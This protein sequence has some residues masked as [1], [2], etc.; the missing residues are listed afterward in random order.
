MSATLA[1]QLLALPESTTG[2]G[3]SFN[4]SV[5]ESSASTTVGFNCTDWNCNPSN[6][7]SLTVA[8]NGTMEVRQTNTAC[9]WNGTYYD[10][11]VRGT[12]P[13]AQGGPQGTPLPPGLSTVSVQV[14]YLGSRSS[15]S[16][17]EEYHLFVSMYFRLSQN[18]TLYCSEGGRTESSNY[19]D[20][21]VR[22]DN[23]NGTDRPQ[24]SSPAY[25]GSAVGA[26]GW[27]NNV[28]SLSPGQ[29]GTLTANATT[30]CQQAEAAWGIS[31]IPCTLTGIEIGTEGYGISSLDTNWYSVTYSLQSSAVPSGSSFDHIVMIAMENQYYSTVLGTGTGASCCPF[32]TSLL[33][34]SATIPNFH[35]YGANDFSGDTISGCSA[36]CYTA[37]TSGG[38]YGVSDG[39][40]GG[41][42]SATNIFDRLTGAGLTWKGFCEDNCPRNADHFPLLQYADTYQSTC[43]AASS[44][45]C[46]LY[47]C[48]SCTAADVSDSQLIAELNSPSPA[49]YIWFTPTDEHNMHNV[50]PSSGDAYLKQILVG[51]GTVSSPSPG[52]ML[53]TTAFTS[54]HTLLYIWFDEYDPSP[55][56]LYEPGIVRSGFISTANNYDEYASL[57]TI[58]NNWSLLGLNLDTNA[59]LISDI[60]SPTTSMSAAFTY[61]PPVPTAG[62]AVTFVASAI[63]GTPVYTYSWDFGDG[64]S[65]TG[66]SSTHAYSSAGSYN[67]L[68]TVKD[69]GSPQQT[70]PSQQTVTVTSPPPPLSASFTF[71]PSSP[72]TEQQVTFTASSTGGTAPY[73]YSWSFGDGSIGTGSTSTHAYSSAGSFTVTLTVKDTGSPQQTVTSQKTVTVTSP[74]PTLT[75]SF[76][77]SPSSPQTGQQ[78]TFTAS[79]GGGTTP[80][81]FSWSFGDGSTGTGASV[82]HAYS[83]AGS[84]TVTLTVKDSGSPQQTVTS[85][86]TVSVSNPPPALTASITYSP[87]SPQAGQQVTFTAS[88]SGGTAP[89]SFTWDFGDGS[90]GTG[91][92]AAHT[93]SSAGTFN[94]ALT[95]RDSGSPQQTANSQQPVTV[96]ITTL[97]ASFSYDPSSPQVGQVVTFT[98]SASG[99][100]SP[101]AFSWNF[102]DGSTAVGSSAT[103][104]YS[105]PGSFNAVLIVN[106]SGVPNQTASSRQTVSV[107]PPLLTANFTYSPSSPQAGQQITFTASELGGTAPYS[108]NWTF[109]D[110]SNAT[111]STAAYTYSSTGNFSVTLTIKDSGSSQ[112]T[113]TSSTTIDVSP[114][115]TSTAVACPGTGI[116]SVSLICSVTV[117]DT[118]F[119]IISMPTGF[120]SVNSSIGCFLSSG[121]CTVNITS[122]VS[123]SLDVSASYGGDA[124]HLASISPPVLVRINSRETSMVVTCAPST[125]T[126]GQDTTC[127]ATVTD[128]SPGM[129][130]T[131]SGNV[132]FTPIGVFALTGTGASASCSTNIATT[133]V[134][135][136][137]ISAAYLGDSNH[138]ASSGITTVDVLPLPP[139]PFVA[140]L[141]FIPNSPVT[142]QTVNFTATVTGGSPPYTYSWS[143]GDG[144][145]DS[146]NPTSHTYE[147][148]NTYSVVLI[149][150]DA[151]RTT[152][153]DTKL[154]AVKVTPNPPIILTVPSN[155]SIDHGSNLTFN[156]TAVEDSPQQ[157]SISC[158]SCP[159]LGADF[160]FN[161]GPGAAYGTFSWTPSE[162]QAPGIYFV[163]LSST[164]GTQI[165][166]ATA[167]VTVNEYNVPPVLHVPDTLTVRDGETL[168]FTVN[169]TDSDAPFENV[170][171]TAIGLPDGASFDPE[172]GVFYWPIQGVQPG[173]YTLTF[174]AT[175]NGVPALQDSQIVVVHVNNGNGRCFICEMFLESQLGV[176]PSPLILI[177]RAMVALMGFLSVITM[178]YLKDHGR[179]RVKRTVQHSGDVENA[180]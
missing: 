148:V 3:S 37:E 74:P 177:L 116:V 47:T 86:Q 125:L 122:S 110:L 27:S 172:T 89:Y 135:K 5:L 126:L 174:T 29:D 127:S 85:Q 55:N 36:A 73:S 147:N 113:A 100:T 17:C 103:H 28:L 108:F 52:S 166:N 42:V 35:N 7:Q 99:G 142:G 93:Y 132:T 109:G 87:S 92:S 119:G 32:L 65:G 77:Y 33:P 40:A 159:S 138:N 124:G 152:F 179:E 8:G 137:S 149:V 63:G 111:G 62:T 4:H 151:N 91:S 131:P 10:S 146:G 176:N 38:T 13:P 34:Y 48:T 25:C 102:G 94:V 141:A 165:V 83:S 153:S 115:P 51:T 79:A 158:V 54:G 133:A 21:Q 12:P 154:L 2:N 70:A 104:A 114:T 30:Q 162:A 121:L 101:Y 61:T 128:T 46:F 14:K 140:D 134:G 16:S 82:T 60:F 24:L 78:V 31:G 180:S 123:G 144:T 143:F 156:V 136:L 64:T 129:T 71:S 175:D 95:T 84:F 15:S 170:T 57:H 19:L 106:D 160:T 23:V 9:G 81:S 171:L 117:A 22:L 145:I 96:T 44:E 88:A 90:T 11:A 41:S 112:Q 75:A 1:I 56:L 43:A 173:P 20:T 39:L 178:K 49:N 105:S 66:S 97:T 120:V 18:V 98:A 80:Y 68:M 150:T 157:I 53:S 155:Q 72:A 161:S 69:N 59:P 169:A 167:T 164:D 26:W 50:P 76:I 130:N 67:V 6:G 139:P 168:Q 45:N 163:V 118:A 58:E 107:T